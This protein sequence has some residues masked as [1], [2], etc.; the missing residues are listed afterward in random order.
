[1]P[2][3][4]TPIEALLLRLFLPAVLAVTLLLALLVYNSLY[5]T[6]IDR[7]DRK[8]ATTS[9][10]TGALVDPADHDQLIAAAKAGEG[11]DAAALE[12]GLPYRRNVEPMR[13]I[14]T[15]LGLTYLYSQTIGA[16]QGVTYV[17]DS[18]LGEDHSQIG[19][20]DTLPDKTMIGLRH[21][22]TAGTIYI[23][24][25][26][27]QEKWGLL[28]T[29]SAPLYGADGRI[30]ASAGA[31]VNISII[32]V[33]TQNA[34]FTSAVIGIG[35]ILACIMVV[36]AIVR[37]VGR[38]I[39]TLRQEALR[40]AAGDHAPPAAIGGPREVKRLAAMLGDLAATMAAAIDARR[41]H[42][43]AHER[44]AN[45]ATLAA[46]GAGLAATQVLLVQSD[47]ERVWWIA[48][49]GA[50]IEARLAAHAMTRLATRIVAEPELAAHWDTL[51]DLRHGCCLRLDRA[52]LTIAVVG[53]G[54]LDLRID[55]E[56][57]T[58]A[59]GMPL[60]L[61]GRT[62]VSFVVDGRAVPIIGEAAS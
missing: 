27:F 3:D 60:A 12:T 6:I 28:K 37:R 17:L 53:E 25:I 57:R 8:L 30:T 56:A 44:D 40:I 55:G 22:Q 51:A 62:Q 29:A 2:R 10:F 15:A 41:A 38:P 49:G 59:S 33:A 16:S 50:T 34:L 4:G 20:T 21:S 14:R 43:A 32:H 1:M 9:A 26:Q 18:S 5:A 24:P 48:R 31:D 61:T 7:F 39:E 36:L 58:L 45:A 23:S 54:A 13:R 47:S 46:A 11:I 19:S 52:A 42:A 35:S